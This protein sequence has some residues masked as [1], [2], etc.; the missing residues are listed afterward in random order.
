VAVVAG[1]VA[2]LAFAP[3][4]TATDSPRPMR[5][6]AAVS[7]DLAKLTREIKAHPQDGLVYYKR[8]W[9]WWEL[10]YY[11][12]GIQDLETAARL[13]PKTGYFL[14]D[15]GIAYAAIGDTPRASKA[16]RTLAASVPLYKSEAYALLADMLARAGQYK[17]S[18]IDCDHLLSIAPKNYWILFLRAYDHHRLRQ[19]DEA[20]KD[21]A[22]A[23]Q[24]NNRDFGSLYYRGL[25]HFQLRQYKEAV[26]DFT[27]AIAVRK[28]NDSVYASRAVA[29]DRLGQQK[30]A[31][32]D[33]SQLLHGRT[34][35]VEDPEELKILLQTISTRFNPM[36]LMPV[37]SPSEKSEFTTEE[38]LNESPQQIKNYNRLIALNPNDPGPYLNKAV[39]EMVQGNAAA[40]QKDLRRCI[41]LSHWQ[42][43]TALHAALLLNRAYVQHGDLQ[44]AATVLEEAQAKSNWRRWPRPVLDY[45]RDRI[46]PR[47]L[48]SCVVRKSDH[49]S[50]AYYVATELIRKG[51]KSNALI[52]MRWIAEYGDR[53]QDEYSLILA[54][55]KRIGATPQR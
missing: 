52:D 19:L 40:A 1:L 28:N 32:S 47:Q 14:R 48:F 34:E 27:R 2:G 35:T 8:A 33:C 22:A 50:A 49:T 29:Y 24:C 45:L 37:D 44:K 11:D 6:P 41:D 55:L 9:L 36:P 10:C 5:S 38:S 13:D 46:T 15:L 18:I 43:E 25:A 23:L 20:M 7:A 16:L 4:S 3:V 21:Y 53:R 17:E 30:L 39:E 26:S 12:R 54:E 51:M 42:G 31:L